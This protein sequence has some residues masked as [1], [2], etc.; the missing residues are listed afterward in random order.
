MLYHPDRGGKTST[1][2]LINVQYQQALQLVDGQI[3]TGTDGAE[4]QYYY[5]ANIEL[6]LMEVISQ[7]IKLNM[8][9][10]EIALIGTWVWI[11]GNCKP[12]KGTLKVLNCKYH[13]KRKCWYFHTGI[14]RASHSS[15]HLSELG[16]KYGFKS[17]SPNQAPSLTH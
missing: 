13:F 15:S 12:Y 1:M 4:H 5:H 16:E 6:A 9:E 8:Q 11:I 17:F 7:L 10:V 14:Y 2:Q 3:S